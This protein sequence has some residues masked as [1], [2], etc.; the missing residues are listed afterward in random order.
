MRF[1]VVLEL[2]GVLAHAWN[3]TTAAA[4]LGSA[5]WVE[6]LGTASVSRED[7]RTLEVFAWTDDVK[8]IPTRKALLIE[9]PGDRMEEDDGLVLPADA[10]VP[11][12][13]NMLQY[14]I[15]TRL[16]R[17]EDM[18]EDGSHPGGG[19]RSG[20]SGG[21]QPDNNSGT[22]GGAGGDTGRGRDQGRRPKRGGADEDGGPSRRRREFTWV[23][24][25]DA[26]GSRRHGCDGDG[27]GGDHFDGGALIVAELAGPTHGGTPHDGGHNRRQGGFYVRD[28]MLDEL[29]ATY[30]ERPRGKKG[31]DCFSN[32][33]PCAV[34]QVDPVREELPLIQIGWTRARESPVMDWEEGPLFG[35]RG[36][37]NREADFT[38]ASPGLLT[39]R[40]NDSPTFSATKDMGFDS[41]ERADSPTSVLDTFAVSI[42]LTEESHETGPQAVD[43]GMITPMGPIH[44]DSGERQ[45]RREALLL[46]VSDLHNATESLS[47]V[48]GPEAVD[49][50][51]D[52]VLDQEVEAF[53]ASYQKAISPVL[54][55]PIRRSR[56]KRILSGPVRRSS[57]HGG[58][59]APGTPVRRQQKELIRKLGIAR[60]GERI[61]DEALEAYLDL[62]A[63]PMQ[64]QHIDVVLS[65]FGWQ[66]DALPLSDDDPVECMV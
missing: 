13:K 15:L 7:L 48:D 28:P 60:E 32:L 43:E 18:S 36:V 50:A 39:P 58:K 61:G 66:P 23:R 24:G 26:P 21:G 9:E 34:G 62:F 55:K 11:L 37:Q 20:G 54:H 42:T 47:D 59:F 56:K 17:S 41:L 8:L 45:A 5:A 51:E 44:L 19:R 40:Q 65:L 6:K 22:G 10:L 27:V 12:E 64:Q 2:T 25:R 4:V 3:K 38:L 49:G 35:P 16:I 33:A 29:E 30:P 53:R 57:R 46:L 14:L 52:V 1:R 63:R 31:Q